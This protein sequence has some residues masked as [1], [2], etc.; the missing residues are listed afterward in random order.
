MT[1][2]DSK[3]GPLAY[4]IETFA[5]AVGVGRDAIY[6]AIREGRLTARKIGVRTIILH[7]DGEAWLRS[8]PAIRAKANGSA[9]GAS[10]MGGAPVH[11]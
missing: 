3:A 11:D 9:R 10:V 8:L 2:Y 6:E 4:G 5:E 1:R 7:E